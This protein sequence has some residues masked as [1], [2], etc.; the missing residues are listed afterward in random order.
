MLLKPGAKMAF[1]TIHAASGLSAADRNRTRRH[2]P[3]F[4]NARRDYTSML[5]GAW[6]RRVVAVDV[7]SEFQ[8]IATRWMRS[9]ERHRDALITT[10]GDARFREIRS[11]SALTQR[12][13]ELGLLRRSLFIATA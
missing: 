12:G 4:V 3:R 2:G 8:R 11:D 5:R 1:Y 10:V 13:I 6:F 7:T 9:R